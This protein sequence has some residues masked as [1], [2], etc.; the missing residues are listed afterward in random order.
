MTLGAGGAPTPPPAPVDQ[1]IDAV[2]GISTLGGTGTPT[3]FAGLFEAEGLLRALGIA[4]VVDKP[5]SALA[6][7]ASDLGDALKGELSP[8]EWFTETVL[9]R[10]IK[11]AGT[12]ERGCSMRAWC[13]T[14]LYAALGMGGQTED[15]GEPAFSRSSQGPDQGA[16]DRQSW[17]EGLAQAKSQ[18]ADGQNG[19]A[20][21]NRVLLLTAKCGGQPGSAIT[22]LWAAACKASG[23]DG[24][25][26]LLAAYPHLSFPEP[27]YLFLPPED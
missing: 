27:T 21:R 3:V 10:V 6:E 16:L 26:D 20:L 18:L 14:V 25:A 15:P 5:Y 12:E 17:D 23:D 1:V 2:K 7:L 13:Y 19:T 22:E 8:I 4:A 24:G 11:A 9:M